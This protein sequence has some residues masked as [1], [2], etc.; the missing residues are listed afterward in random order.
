MDAMSQPIDN[1]ELEHLLQKWTATPMGR[2]TFL[3]AVPTLMAACVS[4]D[5]NREGDNTGQ[6]S[7][8]TV[9]QEKQLTQAVLPE[10]EKDFPRMQNAAVQGYV[11]QVGQKIVARNSLARNPYT[12][13]FRVVEAPYPNAFALPAGTVF[14]TR[15]L[16]AMAET[17]AEL[18]G[19]LGHEIGHIKARHTAERMQEE[20]DD[21]LYTGIGALIGALIGYGIG[22]S[23]C[24]GNKACETQATLIGTGLGAGAG[25]L[26]GKYAF[27]ANSQ[28][29]EMEADRVAFH[30]AVKTGYHKDYVGKFYEKLYQI[31]SSGDE[32]SE[33]FSKLNDAMTTHPPAEE[34]VKQMHELASSLGGTGRGIVSTPYFDRIRKACDA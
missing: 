19:V 21:W 2:K 8:L 18:A 5:R 30:T 1:E 14:V 12:Y 33:L 3:A 29:D 7:A 10:L 23:A 24:K 17:E 16:V 11:N 20:K 6:E 31:E 13:T 34:R 9:E 32:E 27:F 26:I 28:E 22:R 4:G 15:P 25:Y